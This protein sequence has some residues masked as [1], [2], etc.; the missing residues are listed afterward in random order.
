MNNKQM[1]KE[2]EELKRELKEVSEKNH[3]E[4]PANPNFSELLKFMA[5]ERGRTNT[6]LDGITKRMKALEET[7]SAM[8]LAGGQVVQE[9]FAAPSSREVPLSSVDAKLINF[10]QAKGMACAEEVKEYMNYR[11]NNAACARLNNLRKLG[12][13][14]RLQ[15]GHKVYYKYDAGKAINTLIVTPP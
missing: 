7:L 10:V 8:E 13:L 1:A 14:E 12:L 11:G 5:E 6:L 3:A 2:I 15:L 9:E 4:I